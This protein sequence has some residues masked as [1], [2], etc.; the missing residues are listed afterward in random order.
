MKNKLIRYFKDVVH[1]AIVHPLMIFLPSD[2]ATK[3]HD[4][5][6]NWAYGKNRYDELK[7]EKSME[8]RK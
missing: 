3:M 7:I 4:Y 2:L 8:N 6:A 5:N 1:N